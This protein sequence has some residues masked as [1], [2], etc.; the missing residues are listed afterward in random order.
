MVLYQLACASISLIISKLSIHYLV[1][2]LKVYV[3]QQKL[4]YEIKC[5]FSHLSAARE[6]HVDSL[7]N[8][9][10]KRPGKYCRHTHI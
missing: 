10:I 9:S 5:V 6:G 1:S 8:R 3:F 2:S 4:S 7:S